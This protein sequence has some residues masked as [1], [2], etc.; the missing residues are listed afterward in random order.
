MKARTG[1]GLIAAVAVLSFG[2]IAAVEMD[3]VWQKRRVQLL[4]EEVELLEEEAELL[5]KEYEEKLS[6][7]VIQT[8]TYGQAFYE[9]ERFDAAIDEYLRL[10]KTITGISEKHL[11]DEVIKIR[12][13]A[14]EVTYSGLA[15][16]YEGK[17]DVE[18]ATIYREKFKNLTGKDLEEYIK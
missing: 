12:H 5:Q 6:E 18:N 7:Y 4:E 17:K 10:E 13:S 9:T 2:G 15:E 3:K 14:L 1:I 11:S 16:S 8:D